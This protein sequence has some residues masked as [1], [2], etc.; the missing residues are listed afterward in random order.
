MIRGLASDIN[1][2]QKYSMFLLRGMANE[3]TILALHGV[4]I[5]GEHE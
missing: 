4:E 1:G 3:V 5:D 2:R